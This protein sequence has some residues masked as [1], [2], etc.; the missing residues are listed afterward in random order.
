MSRHLAGPELSVSERVR[1]GTR[2]SQHDR[3]GG[4]PVEHQANPHAHTLRDCL[5]QRL[6]RGN[7][8]PKLEW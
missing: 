8:A 2:D 5:L 6:T 7:P 3:L 1:S 4:K